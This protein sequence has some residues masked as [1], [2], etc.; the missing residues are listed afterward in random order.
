MRSLPNGYMEDGIDAETAKIPDYLD[1][2]KPYRSMKE[3]TL[4]QSDLVFSIFSKHLEMGQQLITDSEESYD[5][6][7]RMVPFFEKATEGVN[8]CSILQHCVKMC[9]SGPLF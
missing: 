5:F 2:T 1:F 4:H 3:K 6:L 9:D 8:Q 7:T